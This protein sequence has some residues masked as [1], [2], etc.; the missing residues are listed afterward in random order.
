MEDCK[1]FQRKQVERTKGIGADM[2][3]DEKYDN[4]NLM[5]MVINI[6]K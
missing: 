1:E 4:Q 3:S 6:W 2:N 5:C